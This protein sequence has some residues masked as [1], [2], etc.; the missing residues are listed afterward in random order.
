M[1]PFFC[2]SFRRVFPWPFE[3]TDKD[4]PFIMMMSNRP[5]LRAGSESPDFLHR[6]GEKIMV[7]D[8]EEMGLNAL[9]PNVAEFFNQIFTAA[10]LD[11]F[12]MDLC[13]A[14][15]HPR[16]TRRY[17]WKLKYQLVQSFLKENCI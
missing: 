8:N 11:M 9:I 13:E 7:L 6:F 5:Y 15:K 12:Y 3:I 2:H 14:R 1:D 10:F 17:M 4:V 16:P